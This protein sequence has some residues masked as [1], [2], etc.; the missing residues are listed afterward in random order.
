MQE[1]PRD[2]RRQE[3]VRRLHDRYKQQLV[4]APTQHYCCPLHSQHLLNAIRAI[5]AQSHELSA[6]AFNHM[7]MLANTLH[8]RRTDSLACVC[9]SAVS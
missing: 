2:R 3:G 6:I 9:S 5:M 4:T 7:L 8:A 1:L